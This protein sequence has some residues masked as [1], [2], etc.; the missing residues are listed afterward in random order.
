M[1]LEGK[2]AQ[3]KKKRAKRKVQECPYCHKSYGNVKNH[4][5]M[6]HQAEVKQPAV[7]ITK[8]ELLGQKKPGQEIP[9]KPELPGMPG[10]FVYHCTNCGANLRKGENPCHQCGE[11]LIWDGIS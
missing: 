5:L 10:E 6:Y 3:E 7:Q 4:I 1:K 11:R 8:E 2:V 9:V